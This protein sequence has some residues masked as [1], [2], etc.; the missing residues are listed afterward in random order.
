[1]TSSPKLGLDA[2]AALKEQLSVGT[3]VMDRRPSTAR[4]S[5]RPT[6][7]TVA[8]RSSRP[9]TQSTGAIVIGTVKFFNESK[10]YGIAYATFDGR[11]Q[12]VF[13]RGNTAVKITGTADEFTLTRERHT[14]VRVTG[15][16]PRPTELVLRVMPPKEEGMRPVAAAWG[17]R[18]KRDWRDDAIKFDNGYADYVGGSIAIVP[19]YRSYGP[20]DIRGT[21]Q[22]I[23]MT[24]GE[25]TVVIKDNL[26]DSLTR[27]CY[28]LKYAHLDAK[29]ERT[30]ERNRRKVIIAPSVH[31]ENEEV[32]IILN[33]KANCATA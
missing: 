2:L 13:F 18:P 6:P 23:K 7:A 3:A 22:E 12:E 14:D 28:K 31:H 10:D 20:I 17:I 24:R 4:R 5:S 19:E 1:M 32:R 33:K 27:L 25:L 30:P 21:I 26:L 16:P 29:N 11:Q 8:R 15:A 9:T